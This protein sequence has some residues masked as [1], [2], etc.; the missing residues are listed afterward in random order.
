MLLEPPCP[1]TWEDPRD[2][3]EGHSTQMTLL[4]FS[5]SLGCWGYFFV[6]WILPVYPALVSIQHKPCSKHKGTI[7]SI[8]DDSSFFFSP[9]C[10]P[11]FVGVFLLSLHS[12]HPSLLD[13]LLS[14]YFLTS[15]YPLQAFFDYLPT[16]ER[17]VV[18]ELFFTLHLD[19]WF[20]S[21]PAMIYMPWILFC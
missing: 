20:K 10:A 13:F 12:S 1:R 5:C 14:C 2:G 19:S 17:N 11:C 21:S 4:W 7:S 18:T 3:F 15:I 8:S 9:Y 16:A 6:H